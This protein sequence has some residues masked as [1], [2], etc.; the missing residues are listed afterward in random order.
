MSMDV[1]KFIDITYL[2]PYRESRKRRA[3]FAIKDIIAD[4]VPEH[5]SMTVE[6]LPYIELTQFQCQIIRDNL[7]D[8]IRFADGRKMGG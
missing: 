8:I 3:A 7:V 4:A 1:I 5:A 2:A 6:A